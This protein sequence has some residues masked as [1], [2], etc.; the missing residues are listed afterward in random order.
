MWMRTLVEAEV[1]IF[2]CLISRAP[3]Q[4]SACRSG[5]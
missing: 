3:I 1:R 4:E 2:Q 5:G